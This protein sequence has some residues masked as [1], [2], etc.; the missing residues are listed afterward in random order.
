MISTSLSL[1]VLF[2]LSFS[3]VEASERG[4]LGRD[5][6]NASLFEAG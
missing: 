1:L 6:S 3:A 2:G 5:T 4:Q